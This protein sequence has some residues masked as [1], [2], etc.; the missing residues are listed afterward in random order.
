MIIAKITGQ[1][2]TEV[3][4]IE[5][6]N[7]VKTANAVLSGLPQFPS[8]GHDFG[9]Q[10]HTTYLGLVADSEVRCPK[11]RPLG[12]VHKAYRVIDGY[13]GHRLRRWLCKTHKVV[14]AGTTRFP[15]EHLHDTLGLVK[16]RP[17]AH[18]LPRAKA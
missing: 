15:D 8:L 2:A 18:S 16:L 4:L 3:R 10:H 17:R 5:D 7:V 6:D 9:S 12:L 13:T 14:G 11:E 1:N